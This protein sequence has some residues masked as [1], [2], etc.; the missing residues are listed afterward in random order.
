MPWFTITSKEMASSPKPGAQNK[1]HLKLVTSCVFSV[2]VIRQSN[3]NDL[4]KSHS[5]AGGI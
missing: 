2:H 5:Q 4:P 3:G 1:A